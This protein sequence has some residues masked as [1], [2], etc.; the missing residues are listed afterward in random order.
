M[1]GGGGIQSG[2]TQPEKWVRC[3][4]RGSSL[5]MTR[6]S[7]SPVSTIHLDR[8]GTKAME[9][10][11]G[12]TGADGYD[13]A[14]GRAK[15]AKGERAVV[16]RYLEPDEQVRFRQPAEEVGENGGRVLLQGGIVVLVTDRKFVVARTS[17]GFRPHWEAMTLPY[18]HLEPPI[19]VSGTHPTEVFIPTS[20]RRSYRVALASTDSAARLADA[21]D[22]ALRGYRSE[23]MGLDDH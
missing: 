14:L 11:S 23:R 18:G 12:P 3:R 5:P 6:L 22:G 16:I 13:E 1:P 17:G 19:A 7:S 21:L 2:G 4:Q 15:P 20:G 10:M 9:A 8:D